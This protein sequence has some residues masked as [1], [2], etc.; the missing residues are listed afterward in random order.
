[1]TS[2]NQRRLL[3]LL[4]MLYEQTD[5]DHFISVADVLR[6]WEDAGIHANRKNV[7]SNIQL[8]MDFGHDIICIKSKQNRYFIG[9]RLFELPELKLLADTVVSS[10][11]VTEK[12]SS[13]LLQKLTRL[14]SI[15]NK[16][17]P[18]TKY[19]GQPPCCFLPPRL[20]RPFTMVFVLMGFSRKSIPAGQR[21]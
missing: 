15:H 13:A 2:D 12:K 19:I 20:R 4:R 18:D 16:G 1:M 8:L 5:E 7:Y 10:H 11:F 14:T 17:L 21:R 3:L 9:S 6:S